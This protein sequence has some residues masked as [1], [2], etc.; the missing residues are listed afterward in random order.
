MSRPN[1][2][3]TRSTTACSGCSPRR[4]SPAV[5]TSTSDSAL[6]RAACLD[7]LA[8]KSTIE[9]TA[10]ATSRKAAI[11]SALFGSEIVNV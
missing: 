8:A 7:R 1:A 11:A 4:M 3:R 5:V 10:A 9:A 6:A 2:S